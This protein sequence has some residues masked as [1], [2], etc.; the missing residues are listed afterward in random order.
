MKNYFSKKNMRKSLTVKQSL[1]VLSI[2]SIFTSFV[3]AFIIYDFSLLIP[4]VI[5]GFFS[6]M[7]MIIYTA[8][9]THI[10]LKIF[11]QKDFTK[12]LS[13]FAFASVPMVLNPFPII[14]IFSNI[15]SLFIL[16]RGITFVHKVKW[17]KSVIVIFIV[18]VLHLLFML[19]F[20]LLF[21]DSQ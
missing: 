7:I 4:A 18:M 19:F 12:T 16:V 6:L 15:L 2:C 20:A 17:W 1:S 14:R 9:L 11:S 5:I 3:Y 13:I 21:G 10:V 8:S